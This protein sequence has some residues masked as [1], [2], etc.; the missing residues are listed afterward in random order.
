[1]RY[2]IRHKTSLNFESPVNEHQCEI[3]MTPRETDFQHLGR[4][5]I[6]VE[7]HAPLFNYRDA[8]GNRVHHFSVLEPHDNLVTHAEIEVETTLENPFDYQMMNAAAEHD[9]YELWMKQ[10]PDMWPYVLHRSPRVL[11]MTAGIL[12]GIAVPRWDRQRSVQFSLLE[13]MDWVA[14]A[15]KYES[16]TTKAHAR[17][18][19]VLRLRAGVCQD[20][21][22]LMISVVRSWGLPARYVM[23]YLSPSFSDVNSI[24]NQASHAWAEV[25]VPGAGWRGFDPTHQLV[26]NDSYI[27]VAVGRDSEDAAPQRGSFKGRDGGRGPAISLSVIQNSAQ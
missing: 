12:G 9:W 15:L 25:L 20:F 14:R 24:D 27:A 19:D 22:H 4:V 26:A 5:D 3:R 16:G 2:L 1:M 8:Y 21:A 7:P 10:N 23:G 13:A 6:R 18:E 11:T 17:L